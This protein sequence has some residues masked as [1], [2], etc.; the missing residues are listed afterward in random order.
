MWQ[1][2]ELQEMAIQ[3]ILELQNQAGTEC[4]KVLLGLSNKL[5]ITKIRDR[6]IEILSA[7]DVEP[8]EWIQ[9]SM[10]FHVDSWLLTGYRQLIQAPAG[11]SVEHEELLGQKTIS[12]LLRIRDAYLQIWR[13]NSYASATIDGGTAQIKK[14][15][16]EELEAAIW[17]GN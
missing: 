8:V 10:E 6:A 7:D 16:S 17:V 1:M 9:R 2:T 3:N 11:I 15:F 4:Q 12:K 5:G 14:A 13:G